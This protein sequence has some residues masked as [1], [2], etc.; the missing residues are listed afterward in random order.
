MT[1]GARCPAR[2]GGETIDCVLSKGHNPMQAHFGV[3]HGHNVTW[4][5]SENAQTPRFQQ[6][7]FA[8]EW[9]AMKLHPEPKASDCFYCTIQ[10]KAEEREQAYAKL[11]ALVDQLGDS[12]QDPQPASGGI[13]W[14]FV[15]IRGARS[16]PRMLG[17]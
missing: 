2:V 6:Q 15:A 14:K 3:A 1:C 17:S 7:A 16:G 9:P 4:F 10:F 13:R 8:L 11:V 12:V 5:N